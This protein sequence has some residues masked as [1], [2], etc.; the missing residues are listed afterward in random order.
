MYCHTWNNHHYITATSSRAQPRIY[1]NIYT[2]LY[3]QIERSK[4]S[5][6]ENYIIMVTK[7]W[8]YPSTTTRQQLHAPKGG[9]NPSKSHRFLLLCDTRRKGEF[10]NR[11]QISFFLAFFTF[12]LYDT[13]AREKEKEKK[14]HRRPRLLLYLNIEEW[15]VPPPSQLPS[16]PIIEKWCGC[17]QQTKKAEEEWVKN[18]KN[19]TE[20]RK[21]VHRKL[22]G[23][24]NRSI[25]AYV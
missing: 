1:L 3:M 5:Q 16:N 24:S 17:R 7:T 13:L 25:G 15:I 12:F 23:M 21:N 8:R 10:S 9:K 22:S 18:E 20:P 4:Q 11:I 6:G 14:P 19:Q 2:Y